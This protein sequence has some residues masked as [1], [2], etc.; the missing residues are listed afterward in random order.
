MIICVISAIIIT[1]QS[2]VGE[3]RKES[4][5]QIQ[6]LKTDAEKQNQVS[7]DSYQIIY[8]QF[9]EM[10]ATVCNPEARYLLIV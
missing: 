2:T 1:L 7:V 8:T 3:K 9:N 4:W 6:N 10:N 5:S